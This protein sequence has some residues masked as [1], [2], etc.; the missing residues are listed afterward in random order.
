[1]RLF[2]SLWSMDQLFTKKDNKTILTINMIHFFKKNTSRFG[3]VTSL[4]THILI[5][6]YMCKTTKT[7][8][9]RKSQNKSLKELASQSTMQF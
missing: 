3:S 9:M 5:G 6:D 7:A 1:M 2:H 4:N 8:G